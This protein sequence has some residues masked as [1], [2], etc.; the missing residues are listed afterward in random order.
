MTRRKR[1]L[2]VCKGNICRSPTFE[3]VLRHFAR[4]QGLLDR[5]EVDSAG[6]IEW[7]VGDPPHPPTLRAAR[8]RGYDLSDLRAR[9][10]SVDDFAAFDVLYA[11]DHE[12]LAVLRGLC[13][14]EFE[15]RVVPLTD[16]LPE[17]GRDHVP[18]PYGGE[19]AGYELVL[20]LAESAARVV[21][22]DLVAG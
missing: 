14:P 3:G 17:L 16:L 6:T 20:D 21:L 15:G 12:N 22:R 1:I 10:V 8:R 4:E 11:M 9:R 7:H 18:D 2:F 19:P 13:P 5:I